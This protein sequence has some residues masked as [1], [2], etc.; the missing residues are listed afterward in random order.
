MQG[1][2][3]EAVVVG[4]LLLSLLI[5]QQLPDRRYHSASVFEMVGH[6]SVYPI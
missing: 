5:E 4:S 3:A 6:I 1:V 2:H